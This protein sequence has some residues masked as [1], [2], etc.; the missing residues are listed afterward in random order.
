MGSSLLAL[1]LINWTSRQGSAY[2]F[3]PY[4]CFLFEQNLPTLAPFPFQLPPN[5]LVELG[6]KGSP[7]V[8]ESYVVHPELILEYGHIHI[9]ADIFSFN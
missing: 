7:T 3:L 6:L 5:F 1:N 8:T 9:Y 4:L 2:F